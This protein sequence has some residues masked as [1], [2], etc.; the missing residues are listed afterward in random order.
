[1]QGASD[2]V[3][4]VV[5]AVVGSSITGAGAWI[6][7]ARDRRRRDDELTLERIR[8]IELETAELKATLTERNSK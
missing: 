5:G 4:T 7:H 1:M 3:D 6:A 2:L 8:A